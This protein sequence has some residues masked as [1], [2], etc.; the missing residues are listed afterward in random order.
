MAA[1][2]FP[3]RLDTGKPEQYQ[4]ADEIFGRFLFVLTIIDFYDIIKRCPF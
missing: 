3:K 1:T 4:T 2:K